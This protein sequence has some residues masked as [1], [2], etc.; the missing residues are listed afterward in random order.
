M[1]TRLVTSHQLGS[2]KPV[3]VRQAG[4][5]VWADWLAG[6]TERL[7]GPEDDQ[8][9]DEDRQR[10]SRHSEHVKGIADNGSGFGRDP[11]G[12][13]VLHD[14]TLGWSAAR[15]SAACSQSSSRTERDSQFAA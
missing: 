2:K 6:Q 9:R 7:P 1:V 14:S 3:A 12:D 13:E 15:R 8:R 11:V 4:L 10:P 5:V